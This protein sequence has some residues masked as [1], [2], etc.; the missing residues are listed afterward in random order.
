MT[1]LVCL[2][3][4]LV[5]APA[6]EVVGDVAS[7]TLR[8]R[9]GSPEVDGRVFPNHLARNRTYIGKGAGATFELVQTYDARSLAPLTYHRW[10]SDGSS[11]RLR[12]E[13]TRIRGE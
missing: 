11:L 7:D 1:T 9:V 6:G 5:S 4:S 12:I 13:G 3:V 8:L 2:L 10:S